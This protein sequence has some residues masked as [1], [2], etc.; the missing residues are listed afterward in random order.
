MEKLSIYEKFTSL[1]Y[2][3]TLCTDCHKELHWGE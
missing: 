3:I 2:G 1:K